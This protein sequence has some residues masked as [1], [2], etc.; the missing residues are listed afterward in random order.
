MKVTNN[1]KKF[2][3]VINPLTPESENSQILLCLMAGDSFLLANR[4]PKESMG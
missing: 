2:N 3:D 4:V 1:A